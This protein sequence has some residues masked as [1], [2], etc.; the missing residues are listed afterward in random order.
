MQEQVRSMETA[1]RNGTMLRLLVEFEA[2][3]TEDGPGPFWTIGAN[4]FG[5]DGID[6]WQF[7]GWDWCHDCFTQGE[8]K[9]VGW[10]P[11]LVALP[12]KIEIP[13]PGAELTDVCYAEGWNQCCETFFGNLPPQE[14]VVIEITHTEAP[15]KVTITT[16]P[17]TGECLAVTRQD[18]EGQILSVI[19]QKGVK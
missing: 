15:G 10:L 5:N 13:P 11:M 6:K 18:E 2:H 9:V 3:A 17:A 14:P 12:T 4:C 7:A 16:N 19:W 8:G 1:P